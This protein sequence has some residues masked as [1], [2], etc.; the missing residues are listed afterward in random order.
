MGEELL[1]PLTE[2][3]LVQR[4]WVVRTSDLLLGV[5]VANDAH[6]LT[7]RQIFSLEGFAG[8]GLCTESLYVSN[9]QSCLAELRRRPG[10]EPHRG[11]VYLDVS[12]LGKERQ[13]WYVAQSP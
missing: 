2:V 6:L 10:E 12:R 9:V 4:T 1:L 13:V 5:E 8:V 11:T 7:V 3:R